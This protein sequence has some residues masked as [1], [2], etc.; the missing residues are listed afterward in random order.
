MLIRVLGVLSFATKMVRNLQTSTTDPVH[1][2]GRD[3]RRTTE[4]VICEFCNREGD[5]LPPQI[6]GAVRPASS[7]G[8]AV[9]APALR[10][11]RGRG[12]ATALCGKLDAEP[13]RGGAGLTGSNWAARCSATGLLARRRRRDPSP[14]T[15]APPPEPFWQTLQTARARGAQAAVCFF[16]ERRGGQVPLAEHRARKN[17]ARS[18]ALYGRGAAITL[19]AG[20]VKRAGLAALA[21]NRD[22]K[23]GNGAATR[24]RD[25]G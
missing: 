5:E 15:T 7:A 11:L 4:G 1:R 17:A 18:V 8:P 6:G 19:S 9:R 12:G 23:P 20:S 10:P 21:R 22:G 13:R 2:F 14:W 24:G 16:T 3:F 25:T